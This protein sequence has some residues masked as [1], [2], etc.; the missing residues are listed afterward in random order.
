MSQQTV[1][2]DRRFQGLIASLAVWGLLGMACTAAD[3]DPVTPSPSVRPVDVI[4]AT[5]AKL[6]DPHLTAR[7]T[8][9]GSATR[10]GG[11][12]TFTG[13]GAF[14]GSDYEAIF[15]QEG[16]PQAIEEVVVDETSFTKLGDG[17]WVRQLQSVTDPFLRMDD[18][19]HVGIEMREGERLHHLRSPSSFS[20]VPSDIGETD[21]SVS[22]LR[23]VYDFYTRD[24]GTF[25]AI[26]VAVEGV[27]LPGGVGSSTTEYVYSGFGDDVSIDEPADPWN[28]FASEKDGYSIA[29]PATWERSQRQGDDWF[30]NALGQVAFVQV[31]R[32]PA[33]ATLKQ[34][35][36]REIAATGPPNTREQGSLGNEPAH[37]LTYRFEQGRDKFLLLIALAVH[38]ADSYALAWVSLAGNELADRAT[39]EDLA[40]TF[41]FTASE[42]VR[43]PTDVTA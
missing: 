31:N 21:T 36:E 14:D 24:D 26:K 42:S 30:R 20:P 10:G 32:L 35:V 22:K 43:A 7:F 13:E 41:E 1:T 40:S 4:A 19:D 11:T 33:G 34:V 39:F 17:P 29:H 5:L 2:A 27:F 16:S 23:G 25:V 8:L 38:G 9:N 3:R 28:T 18:L 12:L 6:Q 37:L 15:R